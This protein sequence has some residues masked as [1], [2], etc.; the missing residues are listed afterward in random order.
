[1]TE[2]AH[3]IIS[4]LFET[5]QSDYECMPPEHAQRAQQACDKFGTAAAARIVSDYIAGMTDRFALQAHETLEKNVTT[6]S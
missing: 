2:K 4:V 5:F 1:M 6:G 3:E